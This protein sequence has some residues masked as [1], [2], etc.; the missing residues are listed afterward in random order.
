M[1]QRTFQTE[2]DAPNGN[3]V[4]WLCH[5]MCRGAGKLAPMT[6]VITDRR[7]WRGGRELAEWRATAWADAIHE[8]APDQYSQRFTETYEL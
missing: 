1:E 5:P 2:K 7:S 8:R 4:D 3:G 6:R